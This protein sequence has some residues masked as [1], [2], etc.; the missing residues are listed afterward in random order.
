MVQEGVVLLRCDIWLPPRL[1]GEWVR[2]LKPRRLLDH[3]VKSHNLIERLSMHE[4]VVLIGYKTAPL[5]Y[6]GESDATDHCLH[7]RNAQKRACH[8]QVM[9]H[10]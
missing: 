2:R 3:K 7:V 1:R 8:A 10:V 4:D 5:V 9:A 6:G